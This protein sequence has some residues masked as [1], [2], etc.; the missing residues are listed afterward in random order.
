[1]FDWAEFLMLAERLAE[2]GADEATLRTA[3][4]RAYYAAYHRASA[5]VR[6]NALVPAR[7]RLTH[8]RV[9]EAFA[10]VNDPRHAEVA[11][12]GDRLRRLRTSADYHNPFPGDPSKMA[13]AATREARTVVKLIDQS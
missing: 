5:Y 3:I 1:M 6:A 10:L 4:S 9:W 11:V 2:R 8:Q 12:R 13:S 7:A